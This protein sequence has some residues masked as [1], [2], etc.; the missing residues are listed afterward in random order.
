M[1]PRHIVTVALFANA[2]TIAL[3]PVL[4]SFTAELGGTVYQAYSSLC[5]Q[6]EARS[7]FWAGHP[8]PVCARCT[9]LW[10]GVFSFAALTRLHRWRP[11][12]GILFVGILVLD[13]SLAQIGATPDFAVERF[14]TGAA[15]GIGMGILSYR[16][17]RRGRPRLPF[18]SARHRPIA[19][20]PSFP[21]V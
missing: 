14:L 17:W 7:L 1:R 4:Q 20:R 11:S 13:W 18:S 2:M 15:G 9:G 19:P 5:H 16:L 12:T 10:L 3:A 21:P 8:L 6:I